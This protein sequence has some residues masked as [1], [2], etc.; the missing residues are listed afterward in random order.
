MERDASTTFDA[1]N[2]GG[3]KEWKRTADSH[4]STCA[5]TFPSLLELCAKG[6]LHDTE[7]YVRDVESG[8]LCVGDWVLYWNKER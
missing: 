2:K 4:P 3:W 5:A 6:D 7:T 8:D 1:K